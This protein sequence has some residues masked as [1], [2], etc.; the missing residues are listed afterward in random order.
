MSTDNKT[1]NRSRNP[2][3]YTYM[4]VDQL[5]RFVTETGKIL[6]R[7]IT[8]LSAKHQRRVTNLIK[9]ARNMLTMK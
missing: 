1:L 7:K 4:D 3:D 2:M 9:R 6:P 5:S 8:G